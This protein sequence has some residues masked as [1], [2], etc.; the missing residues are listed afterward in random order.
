[1]SSASEGELG[2]CL[3]GEAGLL[4]A[5]GVEFGGRTKPAAAPLRPFA[6]RPMGGGGN[7]RRWGRWPMHRGPA[8]PVLR[9]WEAEGSETTACGFRGADRLRERARV[10][11]LGHER[12]APPTLLTQRCARRQARRP[13]AGPGRKRAGQTR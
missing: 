9:E 6:R 5:E 1:M 7:G 2:A 10:G 12:R 11:R 4:D 8:R 13:F 3:E